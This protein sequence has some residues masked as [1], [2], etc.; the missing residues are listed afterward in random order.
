MSEFCCYMKVKRLGDRAWQA[1]I[2]KPKRGV[3]RAD[4]KGHSVRDDEVQHLRKTTSGDVHM[5]DGYF[6][7]TRETG[8][9]KKFPFGFTPKSVICHEADSEGYVFR[10]ALFWACQASWNNDTDYLVD[11]RKLTEG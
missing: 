9:C 8:A 6:L 3:K 5:Y 4:F 7:A 11:Y 10:R 2:Q 1:S